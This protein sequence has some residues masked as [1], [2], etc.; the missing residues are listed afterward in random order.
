MHIYTYFFFLN[1]FLNVGSWQI[2]AG[3]GILAAWVEFERRAPTLAA[4][5]AAMDYCH[6]LSPL[7]QNAYWRRCFFAC[8]QAEP[9][10]QFFEKPGEEPQPPQACQIW[11]RSLGCCSWHFRVDQRAHGTTLDPGHDS[12]NDMRGDSLS[13]VCFVEWFHKK[14]ES[15]RIVTKMTSHPCKYLGRYIVVIEHLVA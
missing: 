5:V 4:P 3:S 14:F 9:L 1:L 8:L 13:N 6:R 7:K 10:Q 2:Q 15:W 11:K 12:H